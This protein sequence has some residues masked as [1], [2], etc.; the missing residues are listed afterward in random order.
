MTDLNIL[1]EDEWLIAIDKPAGMLVHPGR[2]PEPDDQIALKSVRNYLGQYVYI[3]HRLD[4][5]TSGV[6]IFTKDQET[7]SRLSILF[8]NWDVK[9]QY[10][11]VVPGEAPEQF[12]VDLP[13]KRNDEAE[14]MP[15]FTKFERIS[16][17]EPGA[18]AENSFSLLKV[19]PHTGRFHQIR[20]HLAWNSLPIMGDYL[21]GDI[22]QNNL[23]AEQTGIKRMMLLAESIHFTHPVTGVE[24]LIKAEIPPDFLRFK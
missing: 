1:F 4:R 14:A 24:T 10:C 15:S 11:A 19:N 6:L 16:F 2:E 20:R 22:D 3:V 12:E 18:V 5:P 23:I 9:K 7:Q 13:V 21:Y 8:Q 17:K